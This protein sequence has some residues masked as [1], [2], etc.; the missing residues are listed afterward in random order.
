MRSRA[1]LSIALLGLAAG[2]GCDGGESFSDAKIEDAAKIEDGFVDGDP[3]CEV[4][5][6]LN[7][8]E[9][10]DAVDDKRAG[11]IITSAV[12]NVGVVVVPPFPDDCEST[13]RRGL[14]KLDP[15]PKETE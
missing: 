9:E 10:I 8:S 14:N 3:F 11:D 7:D 1:A 15:K 2:G 13:V 4:D 6:L 5:D 12:G